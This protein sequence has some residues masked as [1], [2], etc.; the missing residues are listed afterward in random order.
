MWI[1]SGD[2][3]VQEQKAVVVQK[4]EN[5]TDSTES[6][7]ECGCNFVCK[8]KPDWSDHLVY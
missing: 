6:V 5:C 1:Q 7:K 4:K 3:D 2:T 8:G